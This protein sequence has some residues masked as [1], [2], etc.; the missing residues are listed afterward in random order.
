MTERIF[1]SHRD[2]SSSRQLILVLLSAMKH[3]STCVTLEVPSI[4]ACGNH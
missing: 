2:K 3:N 4:L 1:R